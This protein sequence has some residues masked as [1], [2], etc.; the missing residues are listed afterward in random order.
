MQSISYDNA[1]KCYEICDEFGGCY[2]DLREI[3]KLLKLIKKTHPNLI[4][5]VVK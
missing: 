2:M 1:S 3:K 5:E 4:E